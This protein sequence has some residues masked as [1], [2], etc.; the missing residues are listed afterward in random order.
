M[1]K[2]F[3]TLTLGLLIGLSSFAQSMKIDAENTKVSFKVVKDD[4][5]GTLTGME[6][7][8]N[9]DVNDLSKSSIKGSVPVSTIST[10]NKT[11]DGHLQAEDYFNASKFPKMEFESSKIEKTEKGFVMSGKMTIKG[12]SNDMR[13]N[14]TFENNTFE[15]KGI[16][17]TN[18]FDLAS[19]KNKDDSKVLVK[20]TVPVK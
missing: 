11:R 18:D 13:I 19:T 16:I 20:F 9:F 17:Y 1:K 12:V 8:I 2:S 10:G 4:V 6:A 5:S 14:F 15:G 3:I 7:T